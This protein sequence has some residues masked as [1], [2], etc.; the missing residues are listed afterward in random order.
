V[1]DEVGQ[2]GVV[3]HSAGV[4]HHKY[5]LQHSVQEVRTTMD[6]NVLSTI[7]VTRAFLG[8]MVSSNSGHFVFL[9]SVLGV[10]GRP[11]L[12][13][14]CASKFAVTGFVDALSQELDE[15][16]ASGVALTIVHPFLIG[17]ISDVTVDIRVPG[18]FDILSP[19]EAAATIIS[20]VR[21][22]QEELFLP[23]KLKPLMRIN[24]L[25][26]KMCN[27]STRCSLADHTA[28][29]NVSMR[30]KESEGM[31]SR[32]RERGNVTMREGERGNVTMREGERGNVTMREGE[33]GNVTMSER[34]R[35][36][37]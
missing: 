8:P 36:R 24:R 13:P 34:E 19:H 31:L 30:E 37:F 16:G 3:V 22:N 12:A 26:T 25:V 18:L 4:Y 21:R 1:R 15:Q 5:L 33:R 9:S 29:G 23:R 27:T 28:G 35:G 2:P 10:M 14:Y 6:V 7:W 32:E 17:N 20:A 11:L